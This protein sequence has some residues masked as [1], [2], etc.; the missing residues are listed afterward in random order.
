VLSTP[1]IERT[2]TVLAMK[3][4]MPYRTQ[5]LIERVRAR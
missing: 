1:G 5:P 2:S 3:H 4:M